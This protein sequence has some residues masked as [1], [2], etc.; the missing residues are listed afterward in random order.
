MCFIG[1]G[2][3][4]KRKT[5]LKKAELF[6]NNNYCIINALFGRKKNLGC[7]YER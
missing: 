2:G 5:L 1:S 3:E 4:K 6:G 7:A